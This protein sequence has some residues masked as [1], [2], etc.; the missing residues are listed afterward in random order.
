MINIDINHIVIKGNMNHEYDVSSKDAFYIRDLAAE[1]FFFENFESKV[2]RH[3]LS[4][5]FPL[6]SAS[7]FLLISLKLP[8]HPGE[9]KLSLMRRKSEEDEKEK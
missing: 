4:S 5:H 6:S 8:S 9:G 3:I 1:I 7:L 2:K